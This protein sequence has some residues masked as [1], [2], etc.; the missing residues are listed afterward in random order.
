MAIPVYAL[1]LYVWHFVFAFEAA[2]RHDRSS[3]RSSTR[4]FVAIGMLVWWSAL[5]PKRRRLSGELWKIG[6]ILGARMTRACSSGWA[7]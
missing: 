7:S 3:T 1:V 4:S 6:H 2:V 5:E